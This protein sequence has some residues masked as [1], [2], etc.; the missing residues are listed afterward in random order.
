MIVAFLLGFFV[1][2]VVGWF[3]IQYFRQDQKRLEEEKDRL[4]QEKEIVLEFMHNLTEGVGQV[5]ERRVLFEKMVHTAVLGTGALSACV[6]ENRDD[7]ELAGVAVEGLFPPQSPL[8]ESSLVRKATRTRFIEQVLK[9]EKV[10]FGEGI[11]GQVARE[12]KPV[13]IKDAW[14]DPRV[15]R[16][17]DPSLA[18]TSMIVVPMLFREK[19]VGVVAVANPADGSGF[20]ETDF[21]LVKSLAEQA[22][23]AIH[24]ADQMILQI[25]RQKLDTDLALASN[26][27][28]MLLPRSFPEVPG[29]DLAAVHR[30]AQ[31]VGGDMYNVIPLGGPR[32]GIAIADVSGKGVAASILMAIC[33]TNMEHLALG[34][35]SP[36]EVMRAMNRAMIDDIRADMFVTMVYAVVDMDAGEVRVARA[37]HECPFLIHEDSGDT[38]VARI[39]PP[40]MAVG[41]VPPEIFDDGIEDAVHPFRAGDILFLYTDG[42]TEVRNSDGREFSAN[43]LADLVR[44]VH[45][46]PAREI[47]AAVLAA[48]ERFTGGDDPSDDLTLMTIRNAGVS[49]GG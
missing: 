35:T 44:D 27:Q 22:A 8:P 13:L 38:T 12:R 4:E 46:R 31:Q 6:F 10:A 49:A 25:E 1:A 42:V 32:V 23:L 30:P 18:V 11:I 21:S 16:H 14:M 43:R 34:K 36:S 19:L 47:N 48:L 24:N 20:T 40:G 7:R 5:I 17:E 29:L 26:I 41:M 37:G 39:C 2:S 33:Q 45:R 28:G 9:S 3:A 15:Y